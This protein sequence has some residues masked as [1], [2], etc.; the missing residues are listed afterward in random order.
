VPL[1]LLTACGLVNKTPPAFSIGIENGT[2]V[3]ANVLQQTLNLFKQKQV[4]ALVYNE[5]TSGAETTA[6]VNAAR[7]NDIPVVPVTETLPAAK[8]YLTWMRSNI[9]AIG[10]ALGGSR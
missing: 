4:R 10:A 9:A 7:A 5:Q 6:V 2:D 1:Y 8:T 3:P